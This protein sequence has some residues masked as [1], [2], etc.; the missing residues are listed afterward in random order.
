MREESQS[1]EFQTAK[2]YCANCFYCKIL[3]G[4]ADAAA[5][6]RI[7]CMA[8]KW[9]KKLGQEKIYRYCTIG[10]RFQDACD[11]YLDMGESTAFIRELRN[12]LMDNAL[13]SD[14]EYE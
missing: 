11:S 5:V 13:E 12:N 6:L 14:K 8:G 1:E 10:R 9:K 2:V 7:R 4:A 3:A